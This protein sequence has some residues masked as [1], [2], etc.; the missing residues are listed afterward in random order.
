[1]VDS[2]LEVPLSTSRQAAIQADCLLS[3]I[4]A[5]NNIRLFLG[6]L[7]CRAQGT[8]LSS[9]WLPAAIQALWNIA[10][11]GAA[12]SHISRNTPFLVSLMPE[13][14][15]K[16]GNRYAGFL[17]LAQS[18]SGIDACKWLIGQGGRADC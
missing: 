6:Q 3:A 11:K 10:S 9:K 18:P 14:H 1:M 2:C 8:K 16:Q 7:K 12:T 15:G 17:R 5:W 13:A 4:L